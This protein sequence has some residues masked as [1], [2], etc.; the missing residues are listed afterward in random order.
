[1]EKIV[2]MSRY[3]ILDALR[4]IICEVEPACDAIGVFG[5]IIGFFSTYATEIFIILFALLMIGSV[6]M[7]Y[8]YLDQPNEREGRDKKFNR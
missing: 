6:G 8:F 2:V 4:D 7:M 1:M 5:K 3:G